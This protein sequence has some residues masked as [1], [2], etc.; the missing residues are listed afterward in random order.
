MLVLV[1]YLFVEDYRHK[2]LDIDCALNILVTFGSVVAVN[3]IP[4]KNNS[5]NSSYIP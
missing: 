3:A 1:F 5:L 2:F 4:Y